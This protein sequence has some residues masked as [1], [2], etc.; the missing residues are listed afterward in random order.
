MPVASPDLVSTRVDTPRVINPG[1]LVGNDTDADGELLTPF[2]VVSS[3]PGMH[4]TLEANVGGGGTYTPD[5]GFTGLDSF[6]YTA[7]DGY[8][9]GAPTLVTLQVVG[10]ADG[11]TLPIAGYDSFGTGVDRAMTMDR[12]R[13]WPTTST[14]TAIR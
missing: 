13:C 9:D 2:H 8:A 11:N 5:P 1:E 14:Q 10:Q 3:D 6:Y 12:I 4:G 7:F